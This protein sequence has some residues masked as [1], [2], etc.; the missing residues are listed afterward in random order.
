MK[1]T[2]LISTVSALTLTA[3]SLAG[4]SNQN[5]PVVYGDS[6]D[7]SDDLYSVE[8]VYDDFRAIQMYGRRTMNWGTL[9]NFSAKERIEEISLPSVIQNE[10]G[11]GYDV[12]VM[13]LSHCDCSGIKSLILP[14]TML[15]LDM[16][17]LVHTGE[18]DF[19]TIPSSITSIKGVNENSEYNF[20]I[21]GNI[22]SYAERFAKQNNI[23]FAA[24]GDINSDNDCNVNDINTMKDYM[25]GKS[26]MKP[27]AEKSADINLDQNLDIVDYIMLKNTVADPPVSACGASTADALAAPDMGCVKSEPC[28]SSQISGYESFVADSSDEILLNSDSNNE[29]PVYSPFSIYSALAMTAECASENT[30]KEILDVLNADSIDTLRSDHDALFG[31]LY[32]DDFSAYCKINNSMW[33]NDMYK[34]NQDTLENVADYYYAPSLSKDFSLETI[35][36]EISNWI[37]KNTSGK[38]KPSV[39]VN[40]DDIMKIINTVTFKDKWV[41]PFDPAVTETFNLSD[42]TTKECEFLNSY[43]MDDYIG[44]GD[45]FMKYSVSMDSGYKM[46]FILP[47][48]NVSVADIV[49]DKDTMEKIIT[50]DLDRQEKEVYFKAPKFNVYSSYDIIPAAQKL[51]INDAFGEKADFNGLIDYKENNI[52]YAF[53][54]QIKHE[55]T[56]TIDEQGCEAAAYT[57]ISIM[58]GCAAP[59][60][61][62]VYFYLDRPFF[63]YVSNRA[64]IPVFSG[65]INDPT[66]K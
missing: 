33:V 63:Y 26:E 24:S 27:A 61:E 32:F 6:I 50:D 66:L 25:Y 11:Y 15:E 3:V 37:F 42:G 54:N 49:S 22:G 20:T 45:N 40:P 1:L 62:K 43:S 10:H 56:L 8:V 51:G 5:S 44:F 38:I 31:S 23:P 7:L 46:N 64:G 47:D 53:I 18:L 41:S 55:T 30:Q 59:E 12:A 34:Y 57:I 16:S 52:P 35:P 17:E 65:I 39:T 48:E 2:K 21:R 28:T 58:P 13:S 19:L 14:D 36:D 4:Y 29:N 9:F 60:N